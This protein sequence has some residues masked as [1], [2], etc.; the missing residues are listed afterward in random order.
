[1]PIGLCTDSMVEVHL[2]FKTY[3]SRELMWVQ[4]SIIIPSCESESMFNQMLKECYKT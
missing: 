1:M 2:A 4:L 3:L